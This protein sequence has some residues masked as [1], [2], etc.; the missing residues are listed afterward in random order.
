[1][2]SIE[3]RI[4]AGTAAQ[5]EP[6]RRRSQGGA[7]VLNTASSER[8]TATCRARRATLTRRGRA[9]AR[10]TATLHYGMYLIGTVSN[11]CPSHTSLSG[12]RAGALAPCT[13]AMAAA[14][15]DH[16]W[17]VQELRSFRIPPPRWTPPKRRGRRSHVLQRLVERWC[18]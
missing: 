2:V 13:P 5:G 12:P 17:T 8:L 16:R 1:V 7:G 15:T 9:L 18:S 3:R 11:F 14:L 4:L 10:C 6:L